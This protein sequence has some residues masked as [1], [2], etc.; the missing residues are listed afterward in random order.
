MARTSRKPISQ[1]VC[2]TPVSANVPLGVRDGTFSNG[3][4]V[5]QTDGQFVLDFF[6]TVTQPPRFVARIV[7]TLSA[8]TAM[9]DALCES[10]RSYE[11][12]FGRLPARPKAP[13]LSA[14]ASKVR[15]HAND[16]SE[17]VV[18]PSLNMDRPEPPHPDAVEL[19]EKF[20]FPDELVGGAFANRVSISFTP[21]EFSFD[22]VSVLYPRSSVTSRVL[23][24]SPRVPSVLATLRA[25]LNHYGRPL[26][27]K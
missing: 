5:L 24:S 15:Q 9:I 20:V 11:S 1:D 22:F 27:G 25:A 12:Q 16:L 2:H 6:S 19:Y 7:L 14:K 13:R 3:L 21:C 10:L 8:F 23:L 17:A 4:F 26:E 18:P